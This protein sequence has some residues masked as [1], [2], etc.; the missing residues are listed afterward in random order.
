MQV[1]ATT[2]TVRR[3]G[4]PRRVQAL[5]LSCLSF[6]ATVRPKLQRGVPTEKYTHVLATCYFLPQPASTCV[7]LIESDIRGGSRGILP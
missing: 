3:A 4:S 6:L 2:K 1:A 5:S 7:M